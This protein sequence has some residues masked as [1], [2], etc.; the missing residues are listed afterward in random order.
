MCHDDHSDPGSAQVPDDAHADGAAPADHA[1][2][3]SG[4]PVCISIHVHVYAPQHAGG[5]NPEHDHANMRY[6]DVFTERCTWLHLLRRKDEAAP[7]QKD[8][9]DVAIKPDKPAHRHA[10]A[11]GST[12]L[13]GGEG[14]HRHA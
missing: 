11:A 5:E 12:P 9:L 4:S 2:A 10:A 14:E 13:G 8:D 7:A 1:P 6:R 3:D